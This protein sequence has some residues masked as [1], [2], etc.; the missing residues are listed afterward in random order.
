[1]RGKC[2]RSFLVFLSPGFPVSLHAAD[3]PDAFLPPT[4]LTRLAFDRRSAAFGQLDFLLG[5]IGRRM[6]ERMEVVRLSPQRALDIGCGHGQGL[7][8]LR[9]RFPDA[10][11]AGLDISGAMLAEAGQRDPQR[12]PGWVAACSAS[13]RCSTWSRA[14]LPHCLLRP[15]ASICCG[16]T[17]RCTGIRSRIG[18]SPN[19]TA[20][21]AT[22]A[23]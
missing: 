19:G 13:V 9:A 22:T 14:I 20:S 21:R 10:Q 17:W 1:M 7:A 16:P 6:Q 23:W 11:I 15:A 4:R 2:C 18:Y 12:R 3:S 5:E 8:G